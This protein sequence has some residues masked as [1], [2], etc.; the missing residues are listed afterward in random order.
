MTLSRI[1]EGDG[2]ELFASVGMNWT[3]G[4]SLATFFRMLV[5]VTAESLL[6]ELRSALTCAGLWRHNSIA[7]TELVQ[8]L[9]VLDVE[10]GD[11][12]TKNPQAAGISASCNL[13]LSHDDWL[14]L[15]N[16]IGLTEFEANRLFHMLI[17]ETRCIAVHYVSSVLQGIVG[18][19]ASMMQ[20]AADLLERH[21]SL[22]TAFAASVLNDEGTMHWPEFSLL[23]EGLEVKDRSARKLW[24]V[25]IAGRST[26]QNSSQSLAEPDGITEE[27]FVDLVVPW[28]PDVLCWAPNVAL[29]ALEKQIGSHFGSLA[30][31]RKA[32]R[33][34][35]CPGSME[36]SPERLRE[37]LAAVGVLSCDAD[38]VLSKAR[39]VAGAGPSGPVTFE[40]IIE[41]LRFSWQGSNGCISDLLEKEGMRVWSR[42]RHAASPAPSDLSTSAGESDEY[43]GWASAEQASRTTSK[44]SCATSS[45]ASRSCSAASRLHCFATVGQVS[46]VVAAQVGG[47][48]RRRRSSRPPARS[49]REDAQMGLSRL[50]ESSSELPTISAK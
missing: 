19:D 12:D 41:A 33:Q 37:G 27:Q 20:L 31:C 15:C 25:L 23:I 22:R 49:C 28:A 48:L 35:G 11:S 7:M 36:L 3:S 9:S 4:M 5:S 8:Q 14:R 45:S 30:D 32:M 44:G 43:S 39:I 13:K 50:F 17:G 47:P 34:Q 38:V 24:A 6:W 42:V 46:A 29:R 16:T 10:E 2:D 21:G 40:D 26:L 18:P 1:S